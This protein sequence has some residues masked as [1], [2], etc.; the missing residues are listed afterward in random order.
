MQDLRFLAGISPRRVGVGAQLGLDL[1]F[2]LDHLSWVMSLIVTG[3]G[4]PSCSCSRYFSASASGVV[5]RD[6]RGVCRRNARTRHHRQH[7]GPLLFWEL[8]SV[9]SFLL[10][11]F[12]YEKRSRASAGQALLRRRLAVSPY[13]GNHYAWQAPVGRILVELLESAKSG[14]LGIA[15]ITANSTPSGVITQRLSSS[16]SARWR[17][18]DHA[19]HFW[20]PAAGTGNLR[21][22]APRRW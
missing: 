15:S 8:T 20:L 16:S 6:L 1:T 17:S 11:G 19:F 22:S 10:I 14:T 12:N 9:F 5:A 3:V 18:R 21:L 2:R 13:R 7:A 4:L